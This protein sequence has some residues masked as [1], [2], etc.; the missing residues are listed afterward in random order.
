MIYIRASLMK[1]G[2]KMRIF[3]N[4]PGKKNEIEDVMISE[5]AMLYLQPFIRLGR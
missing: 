1:S 3:K 2:D 4:S 5:E